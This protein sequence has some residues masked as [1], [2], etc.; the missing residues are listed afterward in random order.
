M[1]VPQSNIAFTSKFLIKSNDPEKTRN[2]SK[3]LEK[4][5]D[6]QGAYQHSFNDGKEVLHICGEE[7]KDLLYTSREIDKFF[8]EE[9]FP[10][11][12]NIKP[13]E[14]KGI[15]IHGEEGKKVHENLLNQ[16]K[17]EAKVIDLDA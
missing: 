17:Q 3:Q 4:A 9:F 12:R 16:Y 7:A 14:K 2:F 1:K 5:F 6:I 15:F 13:G 8:P 11:E 10:I